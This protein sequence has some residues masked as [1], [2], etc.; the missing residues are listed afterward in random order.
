M[1]PWGNACTVSSCYSCSLAIVDPP[2]LPRNAFCIVYRDVRHYNDPVTGLPKVRP[3]AVN[4]HFHPRVSC[5]WQRLSLLR[6]GFGYVFGCKSS[7]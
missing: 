6:Q 7:R 5:V 4:V 3:K 1:H 2:I